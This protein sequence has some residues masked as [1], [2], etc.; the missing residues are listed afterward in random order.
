MSDDAA[1][2]PAILV[3]GVSK[4]FGR[5]L[6]LD[7]V[8]LSVPQ[9]ETF[10]LLGPNGAGKSS[11]IDILCTISQPDGGRAEIAG[12]DVVKQPLRARKQLGVVFQE[13]TLDTRL[14]VYENLD[15]HGMVY[16]MSRADRRRRIDEMLSLVELTDWR[17]AVARTLS[18]GMRRRLEIA[19]GLMHQPK[20]LF[21]DEPTVGLD[22]QSRAKIWSY[23]EQLRKSQNLTIIVT[24]HYI[25]EVDTCDAICI[26][27]HGKILASGTPESLKAAHGT[28]LFRVTPRTPQAHAALL[29]RYPETV[30]GAEGQLLIKAENAGSADA[31]LAEFGT[32]LRQVSVDQPSLE[33]VFLSLT[34][35]DLREAP[36]TTSKKRGRR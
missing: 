32:Q 14:S 13:A 2:A 26:I 19:R 27:D 3:E 12:I 24:T 36:P 4:R 31:L 28:S 20:I 16:Q 33:S 35:R 1:V 29:A 25:E 10:A 22:A 18:A 17:D 34:G 7:D 11:L 15:F 8:S 9:G 5:V 6:A 21:L 23:L 30:E